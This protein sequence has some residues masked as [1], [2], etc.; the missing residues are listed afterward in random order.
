MCGSRQVLAYRPKPTRDLAGDRARLACRIGLPD[1]GRVMGTFALGVGCQKGG[2]SWLH[3]YLA[4]S[5][6]AAAGFRKEYH[7]F[8]GVDLES[9]AWMRR[10]VMD[11]AAKA[12]EGL[13]EGRPAQP[14][15]G[16]ALRQAGFYADP[17]S[18][19]DYFTGL[20]RPDRVRLTMDIT[21][22]YALLSG[23]RLRAIR[24]GFEARDVRVVPVLLLRD[25]V[26]R[27]SSMV[28]M[29]Q[30]RRPDDFPGT[31]ADWLRRLY[32]RHDHESRT[33][34]DLT[35][36]SLEQAFAPEEMVVA[37]YEELFTEP[38]LRGI[39]AALGIEYVE[40]DV[41]RVVNASP[42][43]DP[44]PSELVHDVAAHYRGVYAAVAARFGAD[45]VR[46]LWPNTPIRL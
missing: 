26:E 42:P 46:G 41:G 24:G 1:N 29:N 28:R 18:Y 40:P 10:R 8:D 45:R 37:F 33:R 39:C 30:H 2:T 6:E 17:E 35:L 34:Y 22:S 5:P 43:S 36:D 32:A 44:L 14:R 12:V 19:F 15:W 23:E 25:P 3:D 7:V 9:E 13:R 21:P 31:A 11:R 16:D 4:S 38:V 27:I 20:L